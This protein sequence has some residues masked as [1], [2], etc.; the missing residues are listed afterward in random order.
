VAGV[1]ATVGLAGGSYVHARWTASE[2]V[3]I[4]EA[5]MT[6]GD[7]WIDQRFRLA[8]GTL[9]GWDEVERYD[10]PPIEHD[11]ETVWPTLPAVAIGVP[12]Q[13]YGEIALREIGALAGGSVAALALTA[14]VIQRRRPG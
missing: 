9:I 13:R 8:D 3:A 2:A 6:R 14:L 5:D 10:P 7:L 1:I 4:D 12:G 11:G